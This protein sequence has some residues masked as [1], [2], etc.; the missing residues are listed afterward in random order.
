MKS[1]LTKIAPFGQQV[2]HSLSTLQELIMGMFSFIK[3][4]GESLFGIGKARRT[5]RC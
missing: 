3:E 4:A 2:G 5:S 1:V